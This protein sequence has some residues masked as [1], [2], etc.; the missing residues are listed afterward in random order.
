MLCFVI[1]FC[2]LYAIYSE[3]HFIILIFLNVIVITYRRGGYFLGNMPKTF[4]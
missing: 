2:F 3:I 4:I 1:M